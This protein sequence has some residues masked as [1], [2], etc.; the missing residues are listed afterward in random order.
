MQTVL[1]RMPP[2]HTSTRPSLS[3]DPPTSLRAPSLQ[4]AEIQVKLLFS[5]NH[6]QPVLHCKVTKEHPVPLQVSLS[7]TLHSVGLGLLQSLRMTT[8]N[9]G[10]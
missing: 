3:V 7:V 2:T 4:L 1:H 5:D 6:D 8:F 10:S 9:G